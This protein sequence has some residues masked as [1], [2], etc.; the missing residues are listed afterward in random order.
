MAIPMTKYVNITSGVG[1]G[2]NV[3][4]R[5]LIGMVFS[6]NTLLD[7]L[8]PLT[9]AG[10]P[11]AALAAISAYFGSSSEEYKRALFYFG[12]FSPAIR[13]PQ[14][15]SFARYVN[16]DSPARVFGGASAF[17]L[18]ALNLVTA[19]LMA[20]NFGDA[21]ATVT[22]GA[23]VVGRQYT[24][25]TVGTTSF[26]GIGASANTVGT[27]FIAT[28]AGTGTGTATYA[29]VVTIGSINLGAAGSLAAVASTLQT[30]LRLSPDARLS[31]CTVTYDAVNTRFDFTASSTPVVAAS[32]AMVQIGTGAT[33]TS[34]ALKWYTTSG[35]VVVSSAPTQAPVDAVTNT[36]NI[37][38]NFGS[39]CFTTA[40][41]LTL[42]QQEA[43]ASYSAALNLTYQYHILVSPSTY[44]STAAAL[45]T[46]GGVGL[47]YE[48][49]SLAALGT[50]FPEMIPMAVQAATDYSQ[51]NGVTNTEYRQIP[52]CDPSVTGTSSDPVSYTTLDAAL[53]NYYG[54]TQNA[55]QNIVFYQNGVLCGLPTSPSAMSVFSNEQWLKSLASANLLSLQLSLPQVSANLLGRSQVLAV[56][57][58]V[59]NQALFNGVISIGKPLT[60]TQKLFIA[61]QTGSDT[62]WIQVQNAG[63]WLDANIVSS[64]DPLSHQ[65][66]YKAVY[67]LIYSKNDAVRSIEGFHELI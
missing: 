10:G 35:A 55:G 51:R 18:T 5:Q 29:G 3:A 23:F 47:T 22:A 43:V 9:F 65:T 32:F 39:F 20:F 16:A 15:I 59:V 45:A 24:I 58:D 7:P 34:L 67:T 42:L 4:V 46:T 17:S 37:S 2:N 66:I 53:V 60:T 36:N 61:Q 63:Y 54:V 21:A 1:G 38:N 28:G 19:G 11:V 25:L 48:I 57:Q 8:N 33:D 12:Y 56:V 50:Q 6:T 26:T 27:V 31:T 40:S 52:G 64:V 44:A 49:D 41:A 13:Q 14:A 30:A 62:A